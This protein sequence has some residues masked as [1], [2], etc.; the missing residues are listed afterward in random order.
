M[1]LNK[2][3][4]IILILFLIL[5]IFK[6]SHDLSRFIL[7]FLLILYFLYLFSICFSPQ[8]FYLFWFL[9]IFFQI[10]RFKT[11]SL[12][13]SPSFANKWAWVNQ[14]KSDYYF[15]LIINYTDEE[16]QFSRQGTGPVLTLKSKWPTQWQ[17]WCSKRQPEGHRVDVLFL[18]A[19][20]N[21][22]AGRKSRLDKVCQCISCY[23][24]FSVCLLEELITE[25]ILLIKQTLRYTQSCFLDPRAEW[26]SWADRE[27]GSTFACGSDTEVC[28]VSLKLL[29]I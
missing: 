11:I 29:W 17:A 1:S 27:K 13:S 6:L 20:R 22:K 12:H 4:K 3:I 15:S 16:I 14:K 28:C 19:K 9:N 25:C 24:S 18:D 10:K 8:S 7:F 2:Y 23:I 26:S 5:L 21:L